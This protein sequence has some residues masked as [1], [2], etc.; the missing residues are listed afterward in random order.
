MLKNTRTIRI[1]WGD[2]DPAGIV[3]YPRYSAM[4]D[5]STTALF[6][7]ALGMNK[8]DFT[9]HY[10]IVGY[11]M[12]STSTKF[13]IPSRYGDEV[14]IET[15]VREIRRA[16]FDVAHQLFRGDKVAVEASETR[17]WSGLDPDDPTKIKSVKIPDEVV[18]RLKGI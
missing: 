4:F 15:T 11:P 17:V 16:S 8:I 1:E 14:S 9:K 12:V 7:R 10:G 5:A 6:E 13:S 2:C 18:N 3:Y